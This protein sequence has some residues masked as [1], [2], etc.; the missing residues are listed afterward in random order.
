MSAEARSSLRLVKSA[1]GG[2]EGDAVQ[3]VLP[4]DDR[5]VLTGAEYLAIADE[6]AAL[7]ETVVE[8]VRT[9]RHVDRE[10]LCAIDNIVKEL[11]RAHMEKKE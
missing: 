8:N 11:L 4:F 1:R 2:D 6:S 9:L 5:G 3:A 7:V 10:A